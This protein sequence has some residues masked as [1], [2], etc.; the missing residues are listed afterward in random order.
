M[1]ACSARLKAEFRK[2]RGRRLFVRVKIDYSDANIDNTVT[3]WAN[4]TQEHTQLSQTYNGKEDVPSKWASLDGSWVLDGTWKLMPET[5]AD[6]AKLEIGWWSHERALEDGT[7]PDAETPLFGERLL[8]E[9]VLGRYLGIPELHINFLAR[10]ISEIRIAFDNARL[11]YAVDFQ[12]ILTD[13]DGASLSVVNVTGNAGLKYVAVIAP[14]SG[15]CQMTLRVTKWSHGLRQAKVAEMFTAI[16][17]TY[18]G[19]DIMNLRVIENR[20]ISDKGLPLGQTASGQCV[21]SIFNR[22]RA[23]DYDNTDSKLYGVVR[24]GNRI[25]VWIGDGVEWV[26]CGTFYAR[27]WDIDK[28]AIGVTV[29]GLDRMA[30]LDDSEFSSNQVIQPPADA[31]FLT[32]TYAEWASGDLA[33]IE[34]AGNAIRMVTGCC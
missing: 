10:T 6:L 28:R 22:Y 20:E 16:T 1:I 21:I 27:E 23:F 13:I 25:T 33:G 31:S 29:T 26:L 7:F 2:L 34:T 8:G 14:V 3:A 9:E 12:V 15:V 19:P 4:T 32:D 5:P 17:E 24:K 18:E 30:S 11:E